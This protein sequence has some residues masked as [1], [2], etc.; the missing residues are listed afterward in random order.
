[1]MA[2]MSGRSWRA[3]RTTESGVPPTPTQ[4]LQLAAVLD[5]R[6]HDLVAQRR[7]RRA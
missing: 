4:V 3:A 5:R 1:M 7:P 6:V 2:S